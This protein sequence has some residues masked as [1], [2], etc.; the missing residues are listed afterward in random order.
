MPPENL[1]GFRERLATLEA[2]HKAMS[3]EHVMTVAS[4]SQRLEEH[5]EETDRRF[6]AVQGTVSNV[7]LGIAS[8]TNTVRDFISTHNAVEDTKDK[9]SVKSWQLWGLV[10]AVF[11][12]PFISK[13]VDQIFGG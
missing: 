11:A 7:E 5:I 13:I 2:E 10:V 6:V 8:L 1:A 9:Q 4:I 3:R 12:S